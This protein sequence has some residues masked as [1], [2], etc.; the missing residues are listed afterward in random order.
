MNI[1]V[2]PPPDLYRHMIY[3]AVYFVLRISEIITTFVYKSLQATTC[4][5]FKIA[6]THIYFLYRS[7]ILR[8]LYSV[9]SFVKISNGVFP[10]PPLEFRLSDSITSRRQNASI[11][12][13]V[14]RARSK[15]LSSAIF[16]LTNFLKSI[17]F[18]IISILFSSGTSSRR[19]PCSPLR[20][21]RIEV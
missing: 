20:K 16:T 15:S 3:A 18:L 1:R 12:I 19:L 6:N 11:S 8:G 5:E 7:K 17:S 2:K 14:R 10:P 9:S 4:V 21:R 13:T